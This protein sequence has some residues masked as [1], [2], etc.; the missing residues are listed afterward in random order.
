MQ[1]DN[2]VI[3]QP[4]LPIIKTTSL[5][6]FRKFVDILMDGKQ[7]QPTM[8]AVTGT[9]GIGKTV[10]ANEILEAKNRNQSHTGVSPVILVT[11]HPKPTPRAIASE[12]A[13]ELS[14]KQPRWKT[15][16]EIAS[17][18]S[19]LIVRNDLRLIMVD[20][21]DRLDE[22]GFDLL[23]SVFDSTGCPIMLVGLPQLMRVI[24]KYEQFDSRV[25]LRLTF[26]TLDEEEVISNFLPKLEYPN[27]KYDLQK[28]ADIEM[29]RFLWDK[30][31]PSLRKLIN[32]IKL[33]DYVAEV[34]GRS[35]IDLE[36]I[37]EAMRFAIGNN[38]YPPA[39]IVDSVPT[40]YEELSER[41]NAYKNKRSKGK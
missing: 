25:G 23:R 33:S 38:S 29:G 31:K 39:E 14:Q 40:E 36:I 22:T 15:S 27:W 2:H 30:A 41:R 21:A 9:A 34:H 12:I 10:A 32:I 5:D 8:A 16:N 3:T 11:L 7:G 13:K 28:N 4:Q 24:S 6:R 18:V 19:E 37:K 17:E 35:A 26:E 20:E 1:Y